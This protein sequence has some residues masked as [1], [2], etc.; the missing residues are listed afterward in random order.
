M[1]TLF[2]L[3]LN[4]Q[5]AFARQG[6]VTLGIDSCV[7][8]T[9]GGIGVGGA[10]RDGVRATR[11]GVDNGLVRLDHVDGRTGGVGDGRVIQNQADHVAIGRLNLDLARVGAAQAVVTRLGDGNDAV[12]DGHTIGRGRVRKIDSNFAGGIP[13]QI[14]GRIVGVL[15][16]L[17][18]VLHIGG[19]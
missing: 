1:N 18:A 17:R 5:G 14:L 6:Q 10:V 9:A 19:E 15:G 7:G 8:A 4:L 3:T 12:T 2:V 13:G 11:G 16:E